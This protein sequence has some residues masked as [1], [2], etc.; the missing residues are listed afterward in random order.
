MRPLP[1]TLLLALVSGIAGCVLPP[2]FTIA[3]FVAG[4][5]SLVGTGKTVTDH[6]ISLLADKDCRVWRVLT[7]KRICQSDTTVVAVAKLTPPLPLHAA[8]PALRPPEPN[9]A[10]AGFIV[11]EPNARVAI[12]VRIPAASVG[13]NTVAALAAPASDASKPA[14]TNA[15]AQHAPT[16]TR[17]EPVATATPARGGAVRGEMVIRSGTDEAEARA[18]AESLSA[19]GA[20]VRPV[21]HGDTTSYEVVMGLSG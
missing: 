9:A 10:I 20:I 19:V 4:G 14:R 1:L 15:A 21:R 2:A 7:A 12:P 11:D 18:L 16:A 3:S 5:A 6:A 17:P 13:R 8:S